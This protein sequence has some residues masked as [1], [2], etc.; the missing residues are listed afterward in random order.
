MSCDFIWYTFYELL[1]FSKI[2]LSVD[3]C[4]ILFLKSARSSNPLLIRWAL[5]MS[6][7]DIEIKHISG[8]ENQLADSLSR[9]R[10]EDV[11]SNDLFLIADEAEAILQHITIPGSFT[12]DRNLFQKFITALGH[13]L[14]RTRKRK[15]PRKRKSPQKTCLHPNS[16]K[17]N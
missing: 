14:E 9:S 4:S 7:F 1:C 8:T 3:A 17:G 10:G 6:N 16:Q 2:H 15:R 12:I 5:T 11:D 13:L